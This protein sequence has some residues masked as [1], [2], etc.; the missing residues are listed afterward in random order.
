VGQSC[1]VRIHNRWNLGEY[2]F[3]N[4]SDDRLENFF[5]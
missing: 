3:L 5:L 4:F 2:F 1:K